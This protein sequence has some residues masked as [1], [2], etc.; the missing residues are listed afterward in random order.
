MTVYVLNRGCYDSAYI[1]GVYSTLQLAMQAVI[2][3][4][5]TWRKDG[6]SWSNGLDWDAAASIEPY[7]VDGGLN[8]Q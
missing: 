5:Q 1:Q 2:M 6:E 3:P 4:K 8:P 7:V